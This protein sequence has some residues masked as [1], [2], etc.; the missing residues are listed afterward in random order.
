MV[1]V[2]LPNEWFLLVE[3]SL[4]VREGE[5]APRVAWG[6]TWEVSGAGRGAEGAG[7]G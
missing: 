5:Q 2:G 1:S 3:E 6:G 7:D 4:C